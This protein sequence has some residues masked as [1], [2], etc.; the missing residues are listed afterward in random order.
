MRTTASG[1]TSSTTSAA[2]AKDSRIRCT[3][4]RR[5][6]RTLRHERLASFRRRRCAAGRRLGHFRRDGNRIVLRLHV[7]A[8]S[9]LRIELRERGFVRGARIGGAARGGKRVAAEIRIKSVERR[10]VLGI[11]RR[12]RRVVLLFVDLYLREAIARDR[13]QLVFGC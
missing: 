8:I 1:S 5:R 7:V 10:R 2:I 4:R 12:E 3:S 11:E 13:L 9:R 6:A